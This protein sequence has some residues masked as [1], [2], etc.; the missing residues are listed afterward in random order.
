MINKYSVF[1][2]RN[3]I[4]QGHGSFMLM[5]FSVR[6]FRNNITLLKPLLLIS[7]FAKTW[8]TTRRC[9][10]GGGGADEVSWSTYLGG[11]QLHA[12]LTLYMEIVL[13]LLFKTR[14]V[15]LPIC[16]I[17]AIQPFLVASKCCRAMLC[18]FASKL[19]RNKLENIVDKLRSRPVFCEPFDKLRNFVIAAFAKRTTGNGLGLIDSVARYRKKL[20]WPTE[21]HRQVLRLN[22]TK[23]NPIPPVFYTFEIV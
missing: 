21:G 15:S 17:S 19:K 23:N 3:L 11:Q 7:N 4:L 16:F 14:E 2:T 5:E 10:F 22:F 8:E 13:R 20:W 9:R 6:T 12:A 1:G 18:I